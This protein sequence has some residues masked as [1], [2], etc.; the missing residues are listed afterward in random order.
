MNLSLFLGK[1]VNF[2]PMIIPGIQL[3]GVHLFFELWVVMYFKGYKSKFRWTFND[4]LTLAQQGKHTIVAFISSELFRSSNDNQ[5]SAVPHKYRAF[6]GCYVNLTVRRIINVYICCHIKNKILAVLAVVD[7]VLL[8]FD[9][10]YFFDLELTDFILEAII[11]RIVLLLDCL[12]FENIGVGLLLL[13]F[14]FLRLLNLHWFG[15]DGL[16]FNWLGLHFDAFAAFLLCELC[17][18]YILLGDVLLWVKLGIHIQG[19]GFFDQFVLLRLNLHFGL[20]IFFFTQT[21]L[22]L[23]NMLFLTDQGFGGHFMLMINLISQMSLLCDCWRVVINVHAI[24][25]L[26]HFESLLMHVVR[27]LGRFAPFG[28]QTRTNVTH[29]EK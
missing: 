13:L 1:V 24:D 9:R 12:W 22:Y 3:D 26:L 23:I 10:V 28:T 8:A 7:V 20:N 16:G 14:W 27:C 11:V 21:W 15:W 2:W 17:W 29:W 4:W 18:W 6:T 5:V 25:I 19:G